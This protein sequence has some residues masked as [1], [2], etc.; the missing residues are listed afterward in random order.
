VL[1]LCDLNG[2][3]N[4][5][6]TFGHPA[7]DALLSRVGAALADA[8]QEFGGQ[9]YRQGGDE[10]CVVASAA[11]RRALEQA[12]NDALSE[13]GEGFQISTAY[14][15]VVLPLDTGDAAEALRKADQAMYA[16]KYSGR[17]TAGR[18]SS[19][20][21]MRAL[22]ERHPDLGD[23]HNGVAELAEQVGARL[24]ITGHAQAMLIHAASLHDIGKVA[25][26]DA[27]L[28]KPGPLSDEEWRFMRRHTIIGE[29]ILVAAPSLGGAAALVRSSHESWDGSGYPDAL[30]GVEIPLGARIIAICDA[31]DAMISER[32]YSS[33]KSTAEALAEL[34]RCADTQFDPTI[35]AV[36]EQVIAARACA[37]TATPAAGV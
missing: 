19:D 35:V 33:R 36:F 27:I 13:R 4:Y 30:A 22:A 34:R 23:H 16:Q 9:A 7:G 12:A 31:F 28:A 5:N 1:T 29:R 3:K 14:G 32:P 8:V 24:G 37:P 17:A 21:L 10:F 26:P 6:D 15:S 20:V 11:R 18:Q 2:F 25:I